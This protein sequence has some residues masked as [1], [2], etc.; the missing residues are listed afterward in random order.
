MRLTLSAIVLALLPASWALA[1]PTTTT[2]FQKDVDGYTDLTEVRISMTASRDGTIGANVSNYLIDGWQT[3]DPLTPEIEADSPDEQELIKFGSLFGTGPGQIPQGATI[4]DAKLTYKTY[5][6]GTTPPSPGPW[7]V[8]ALNQPFTTAT[9][10]ADF[11]SSN[12]N[13]LLPSR[14]AWYQDG[15]DQVGHPYATRPTGAFASPG[16]NALGGVSDAIVTPLIQRWSTDTTSNNGFVVQAGWTGQTNGW[17]FFTNGSSTAANRPKL[18]VTYTQSPLATTIIQR[19]LNG[20]AADV[21]ARIDS[22]GDL[23]GAGDDVTTDGSTA[24]TSLYLDGATSSGGTFTGLMRFPNVF[25]GNTG[26]AP[27]DKAVAKAWLVLTT[28]TGDDHRSNS[29]FNVYPMLRDWDLDSV[30]TSKPTLYSEFGATPGFQDTDGDI[31]PLVTSHVGGTN[32]SES[33]FDIT[34]YLESVRTGTADY[35]LAIVPVGG[36]GWAIAFNGHTTADIRPRLVIYSDLSASV[37]LPG[38]FNS[39][40]KVDAG[41]Y[42]TWRK[43]ETANAALANDNGVG[44]QAAR[45]ALWRANFGNPQGSG[46]GLGGSAAVPEPSIALLG[47]LMAFAFGACRTRRGS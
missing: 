13:P 33:W 35:G 32:G 15:Q 17:G 24:A 41:D 25:G 10:Y 39:D 3:D 29:M 27:A 12:G 42:A 31:G 47:G 28:G 34:S 5:D 23:V 22:G 36:D 9:R 1:I 44:N 46:T 26:Q 19:G 38:D 2:S 45:F 21:N 37:N 16:T 40:G 8:A 43:N 14:G 4:L 7:G 20:Y 18:T 30:D 6:T 11:P